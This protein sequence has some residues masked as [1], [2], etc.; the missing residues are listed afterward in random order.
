VRFRRAS[1]SSPGSVRTTAIASL[2]VRL[3]WVAA[4]KAAPAVTVPRQSWK[5]PSLPFSALSKAG[6]SITIAVSAT[7]TD[8]VPPASATAIFWSA[9]ETV[10]SGTVTGAFGFRVTFFGIT[11]Y[12]PPA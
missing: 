12:C 5:K 11:A 1:Q 3:F 10:P 7:A 6:L 8:F 2:N 9:S 4:T